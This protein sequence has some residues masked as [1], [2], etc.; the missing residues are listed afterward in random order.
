MGQF[1]QNTFEITFPLADSFLCLVCFANVTSTVGLNFKHV[2]Y[3]SA[4]FIKKVKNRKKYL[5]KTIL[6]S[7]VWDIV[8]TLMI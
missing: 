6:V 4:T 8:F 5:V 1:S 2:E 3:G 7:I